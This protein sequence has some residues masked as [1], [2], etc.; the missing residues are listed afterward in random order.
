MGFRAEYSSKMEAKPAFQPSARL[1]E[2]VPQAALNSETPDIY[3]AFISHNPNGVWRIELKQSVPVSLDAAEQIEQIKINGFLAECNDVLARMYGH[4]TA[5][6][7]L[8]FSGEDFPI[9]LFSENGELLSEFVRSA[10]QLKNIR[11][12]KTDLQGNRRRFVCDIFGVIEQKQ[13]TQ[14]W[15][16]QREEAPPIF[17]VENINLYQPLINSMVAHI[18]VIDRSGSII[19]I[20]DAWKRFAQENGA[21]NN[22][23]IGIG[24]NYLEICACSDETDAQ[25]SVRGIRQV[26]SGEKDCFTYE[27][28]CHNPTGEERWFLLHVTPLT[29]TGGAVV[30]HLNIT[31]RKNAEQE[32]KRTLAENEAINRM[33]D[34]FLSTVSHEL[35]TPLTSMLGWTRLLRSGKLDEKTAAHGLETIERNTQVQARLIEDLLDVS[36]I[37][38]GKLRLDARPVKLRQIVES[39]VDS[40]RP[41][42]S[43][44]HLTVNFNSDFEDATV[45]ADPRRIQQVLWNLLTNAI[46]FTPRNGHIDVRTRIVDS[47]VEVSVTDSG[48]GIKSEFL[49]HLFER[50]R[51]EDGSRTRKHGG[52]GLGLAIVRHLIELHGG[53]VSAES[54]GEGG[55]ATFKFT[56]PV[57][58]FELDSLNNIENVVAENAEKS[59]AGN[60]SKLQRLEG[61]NLLLVDDDQDNLDLLSFLFEAAGAHIETAS[62]AANALSKIAEQKFDVLISDI[63]MPDE[64][65]YALIKKIRRLPPE[66]GGKMPAIALTAY[67]KNE[68][69]LKAISSGFQRHIKKPVEPTDLA[70]QVAELIEQNQ[71][72]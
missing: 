57:M 39:A 54:A 28:P 66:K 9:D 51:Q 37:I 45:Y 15:G 27:Y 3:S 42:A 33:K 24:A 6:E 35:R 40:N 18:A 26:L 49:P 29:E 25:C 5:R 55:G 23:Q 1:G 58:N 36:R 16:M 4:E 71:A 68:D 65:G 64:D 43:I 32:L 50:F 8:D 2:S 61:V 10:Y 20:N 69:R 17:N 46:K 72:K 13:L 19:T 62:S 22:E 59:A 34:E 63:G 70:R 38:N 21:A 56:L 44:K 41:A 31:K 67:A 30:S 48:I 47:T 12:V 11:S 14:I 52:M 53:G 60:G 7:M